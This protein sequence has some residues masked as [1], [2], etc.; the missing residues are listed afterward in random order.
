MWFEVGV[1]ATGWRNELRFVTGTS[2]PHDPRRQNTGWSPPSP[3]SDNATLNSK[4]I[5][6]PKPTRRKKQHLWLDKGYDSDDARRYLRKR[7]YTPH[8]KHR[9]EEARDLKTKPGYRARRWVV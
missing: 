8:I 6:R 7:H 9:G 3:V 1:L 2:P 4:S 5:K